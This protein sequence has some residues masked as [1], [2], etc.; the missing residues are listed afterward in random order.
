VHLQVLVQ[1]QPRELILHL[2]VEPRPR[3][4]LAAVTAAA[5]AVAAAE[6]LIYCCQGVNL[7]M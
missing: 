3:Q 6:V 2:V 4:A 5:A 7:G 1:Q